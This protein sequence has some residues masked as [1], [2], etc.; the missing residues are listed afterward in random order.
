MSNARKVGMIVA[1]AVVFGLVSVGA[2]VATEEK[3]GGIDPQ[4]ILF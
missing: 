1:A 2:A 3:V 4:K